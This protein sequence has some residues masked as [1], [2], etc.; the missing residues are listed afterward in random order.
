MKFVALLCVASFG[1]AARSAGQKDVKADR[2]AKRPIS[3]T[4][5]V[6][7]TRLADH[8]YFQGDSSEGRVAHF[9][10]NGKRFIVVLK[11][12]NPEQNTNEFSLLLFRTSDAFES[13]KPEL[14]LT[15]SSSS[16]RDAIGNLTWLEDNRTVVFVGENPGELP[17]IYA[18]DVETKQLAK[19]T[20]HDTPVVSFSVSGNGEKLLFAADPPA[21]K[22]FDTSEAR[23][24]GVIISSQD[25][26]NDILAGGSHGYRRTLSEGE[27]LFYQTRHAA[28][29][30]VPLSDVIWADSLLSFS[31][32]G[33][34]AVFTAFA[35][36][37]P[38]SWGDY[39]DKDI[40][41]VM[42]QARPKGVAVPLRRYM[43][44]D[45]ESGRT[46]PLLDSP[47]F[48]G[49]ASW[50]QSG[51]KVLI[52]ETFLPLDVSDRVEREER[53]KSKYYAEIRLPDK[54]YRKISQE[55]WAKRDEADLPL[56]VVLEEDVN[57]PPKIYASNTKSKRKELLLD[58]NPQF[59]ELSF[60]KVE[61]IE[62]KTADGGNSKGGLYLPPDYI[63]EKKYP[64]IIQT[65]GFDPDIRF[66]M[67]GLND[68]SSGFAARPLA[69]RGFLVLQSSMF[70]P[71]YEAPG[72]EA[73][74]E[75]ARYEGAIDYLDGRGL[76][77]R[78]R[79][80]I[81]GFSRTVYEVGYA[82]THSKYHFAA[83][84]LVDG[85]DG[86]YLQ[87]LSFSN[88]IP[89]WST[90]FEALNGGSPFG[91]GLSSWLKNSPG[92]NLD[93]MNAPLRLV[94]LGPGSVLEGWQWYSG[95]SLMNKPVD[96]V[97][98]PDA[99]H[100][101]VK[102]WEQ[103]TAQQGLVDWFSFWLKGEEDPAPAKAQQYTRWREMQERHGEYRQ[104]GNLLGELPR[105]R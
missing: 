85:I 56:Q 42:T 24:N 21:K 28:P 97:Y 59:Q 55:D 8:E 53:R 61:V 94:A 88:S 3:T 14:L 68:W 74:R 29:A 66:S 72:Q 50:A 26:V 101:I 1:F 67:D 4:D 41:R 89:G 23:R 92:F 75:M 71:G 80:G 46:E 54:A 7:T 39:Q 77:D 62:W 98:L 33:R 15:M 100:L 12:G 51:E 104:R 79:V 82:L 9:S 45:T 83:A 96:F 70:A 37:V 22:T 19:L 2:D 78:T 18:L 90:A 35:R 102:P 47:V 103:I 58:L 105:N 40:A 32:D 91:E 25:L 34:Y 65:H 60:G 44:F 84:V 93:K 99:P 38:G 17:Q 16:N 13:P 48:R 76:I 5:A 36:K 43:V 86:S 6:Q 73:R 31:P 30:A 20:S 63:P 95:L 69:A 57:T 11:K 27:E 81:V 87:Y 49:R 64:L 10:Q 52:P